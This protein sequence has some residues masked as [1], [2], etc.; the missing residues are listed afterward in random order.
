MCTWESSNTFLMLANRKFYFYFL[1]EKLLIFIAIDM[2]FL[3]ILFDDF[4]YSDDDF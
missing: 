2:R 1:I 3:L 4:V